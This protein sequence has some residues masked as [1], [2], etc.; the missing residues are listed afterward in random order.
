MSAP[1]EACRTAR[2]VVLLVDD[3]PLIRR[4]TARA[5]TEADYDVIEAADGLDALKLLRAGSPVDIV[6]SDVMMPHMTGVDLAHTLKDEFPGVPV[7]LVSGYASVDRA[8]FPFLAKPFQLPALVGI[9]TETLASGPA[10][11]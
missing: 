5:L 1:H 6:V 7:I 4:L 10:K 11:A 8:P 2:C 9:I 3:E